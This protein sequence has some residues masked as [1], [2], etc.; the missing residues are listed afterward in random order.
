MIQSLIILFKLFIFWFFSVTMLH[1]N[2]T[3]LSP[4]DSI[5]YTSQSSIIFKG[6]IENIDSLRINNIDISNNLPYFYISMPLDSKNRTNTFD[7]IGFKDNIKVYETQRA[8]IRPSI[9][10]K[11]HPVHVSTSSIKAPHSILPYQRSIVDVYNKS[12]WVYDSLT[13]LKDSA[14]TILTSNLNSYATI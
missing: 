9:K 3:L 7:L 2:V 11:Q 14:Q 13:Q 10:I 8:V 5:T 12:G 6:K 1:A 4:I